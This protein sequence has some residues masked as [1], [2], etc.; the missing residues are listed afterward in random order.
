[1]KKIITSV[2]ALLLLVGVAF[3]QTTTTSTTLSANVTSASDT[4]IKVTSATG[5][6]AGSTYA[7]VDGEYMDVTGVSG[8]SISVRRGAAS[9]IPRPHTSG[10]TIYV[11]PVAVFKSWPSDPDGRCTSTEWEYLP[12]INVR[13]ASVIR[14]TN[15]QWDV[16]QPQSRMVAGYNLNLDLQT[17]TDSK[18]VRINSRNYSTSGN[19]IGF[20]VKPA[21]NANGDGIT[22]GEISPRHS[23]PTR[24][25]TC[26]WNEKRRCK[27]AP[28]G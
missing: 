14:C 28:T 4:L 15:S 7:F 18:P 8:T 25:W 19:N 26:C 13:T 6:T 2:F 20:Q 24:F 12:I 17:S 21:Q 27:P 23:T 16:E 3:G 9:T 5:F 10:A 11:G 1:M 22:G